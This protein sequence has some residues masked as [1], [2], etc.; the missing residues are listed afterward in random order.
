MDRELPIR[1]TVIEPPPGVTFAMQRGKN[2]LLPPSKG[3][4]KSLVFKLSI[5]VSERKAG[6]APNVL[7]PYAHKEVPDDRFLYLNSVT[8]AGQ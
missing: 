3:S 6:G 2:E 8:M 5:R 4:A 7:G 1:V